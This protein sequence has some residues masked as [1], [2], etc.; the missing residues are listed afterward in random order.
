MTDVAEWVLNRCA[1]SGTNVTTNNP[2][3]ID[4]QEET[5]NGS[6]SQTKNKGIAILSKFPNCYSINV[7]MFTNYT[8][9]RI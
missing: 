3:E 1:L 5:E 6:D 2:S 8:V 9:N 7:V 4:G